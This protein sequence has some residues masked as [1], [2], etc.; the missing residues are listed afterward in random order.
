MVEPP[1]DR[2]AAEM[3]RFDALPASL[4]NAL[5]Q[6]HVGVTTQEI[7]DFNARGRTLAE[8]EAFIRGR[9]GVREEG[10][11]QRA[12]SRRHRYRSRIPTVV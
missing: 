10:P 9:I 4:K 3:A 6:A 2:A 7:A 1:D 8:I 11:P 5:T 12:R